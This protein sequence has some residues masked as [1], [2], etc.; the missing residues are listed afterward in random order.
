MAGVALGPLGAGVLGVS[1]AFVAEPFAARRFLWFAVVAAAGLPGISAFALPGVVHYHVL[2]LAMIALTGGFA[3][4]AWQGEVGPAFLAGLCGGL[5]IWLTPET[6]PFVLMIFA[7]LL[8]QWLMLPIGVAVAACAAGF[9]D[10]IGFGFT[11]DPPA[12]GYGVVETDRLSVIYVVL[13]L[14]LL[15]GALALW[16]LERRGLWRRW[17]WWGAV[18]MAGLI[19]AWMALFPAVAEGPYGLMSPAQMRGFFGVMTELQPLGRGDLA[20][21]LLPG[22]AALLYLAWRCWRGAGGWRGGGGGGGG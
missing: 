13:A 10:A 7:A 17:R 18:G 20:P 1:V 19:G 6:M 5:A 3:A 22:A 21:Y 9:V 15:A 4:R 8:G 16:R 11:V 12:G 2:L 14:L